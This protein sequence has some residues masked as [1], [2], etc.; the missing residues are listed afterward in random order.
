M[1]NKYSSLVFHFNRGFLLLLRSRICTFIFNRRQ[2]VKTAPKENVINSSTECKSV[3]SY[4]LL[5]VLRPYFCIVCLT[6]SH[7][8]SQR[9]SPQDIHRHNSALHP[10]VKSLCVPLISGKFRPE[11]FPRT[12]ILIC[13]Y[14]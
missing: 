5:L 13:I 14:L 9:Q 1:Y 7:L 10:F 4:I 6:L 2:K 8:N 11:I 3:K 12:G